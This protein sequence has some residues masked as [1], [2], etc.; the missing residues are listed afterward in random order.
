MEKSI[1]ERIIRFRGGA[2]ISSD[3]ELGADVKI[4]VEGSIVG[5]NENDNQDGTKDKI[6][7]VKQITADVSK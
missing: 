6:F 4:T 3:F 1:N 5:I 2:S 7:I